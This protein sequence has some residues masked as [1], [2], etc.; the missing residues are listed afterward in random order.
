MA[1]AKAMATLC[2]DSAELAPDVLSP[3]LSVLVTPLAVTVT[4]QVTSAPVEPVGILQEWEELFE[5]N[6][7]EV[8][9]TPLISRW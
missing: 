9:V 3:L 6:A 1:F 7:S 4:E 2:A 8:C 5:V